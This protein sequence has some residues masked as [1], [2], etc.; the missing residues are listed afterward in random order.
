MKRLSTILFIFLIFTG[1]KSFAYVP[2]EGHVTATFGPYVYKTKFIHPGSKVQVPA[3][4]GWTLMANGDFSDKES[5]EIALF[6][7][8][9]RFYRES[10]SQ[11]LGEESELI[12]WTMG[13]RRWLTPYLSWGLG[14]FSS[15]T[16]GEPSVIYNDFEP[17]RPLQ[18]S[19]RDI[20]E[21]G[22]DFSVQVELWS[23]DRLGAIADLRYSSSLTSRPGEQGDH[24]GAMIGIKYFIQGKEKTPE[25][26]PF[27]DPKTQTS[28]SSQQ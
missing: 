2:T 13:Y 7:L 15:Y 22:V 3:L 5:L 10:N 17:Q 28:D 18:T 12:S 16:M 25:P 26:T 4:V 21:Y 23:K 14:I 19:A 24:Y 11:F 8:R 9:K 6:H 20:T 27:H 1:W